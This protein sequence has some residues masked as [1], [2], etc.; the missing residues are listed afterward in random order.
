M[1]IS[2]PGPVFLPLPADDELSPE[3]VAVRDAFLADHHGPLS[4]L[5]RTL[6]GSAR[7]FQAYLAWYAVR[8]EAVPYLGERAIDLFSLAISRAFGASYPVAFFE[9]SLSA[10]G[11]DPA[12][13]VVTEAEGLLLEWGTAIGS[14]AGAIPADL[15]S[16]VEQTFQPKLR[17]ALS[18]FAGQMVAVCVFTLVGQVP[19]E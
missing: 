19:A 10:R 11:D 8:D 9:H 12:A 17:L 13:P 1:S 6:L 5:D 4:N 7:V 18:A 15:T 14:N 16:R 3:A 2:D